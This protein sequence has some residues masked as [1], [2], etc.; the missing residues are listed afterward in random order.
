MLDALPPRPVTGTE[1]EALHRGFHTLHG[2]S[3]S[4][5]LLKLAAAA[6]EGERLAKEALQAEAPSGRTLSRQL[7]EQLDLMEREAA[8]LESGQATK[9]PAPDPVAAVNPPG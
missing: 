7:L 2:S 8:N 4:F 5:G 9:A 1:L 6:A 3:A